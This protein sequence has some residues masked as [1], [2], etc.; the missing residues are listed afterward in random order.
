MNIQINVRNKNNWKGKGFY[1]ELS[2]LMNPFKITN[3]QPRDMVIQ[4]YGGLLISAIQRRDPVI[5]L[6]LQK[7]EGHIR[8]TKTIDL[9]CECFPKL[10]HGDL[11]KQVLV[12]KIVTNYWLINDPCPTCHRA[13]FKIGIHNL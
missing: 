13:Q 9:I 2:A 10:C 8:Q 1:L 7:L 3:Q 12:N 4:R 5:I 6:A 11:I